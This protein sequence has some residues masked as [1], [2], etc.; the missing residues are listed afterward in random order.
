MNW[1][2]LFRAGVGVSQILFPGAVARLVSESADDNRTL[3]FI[4]VLGV[5]QLVQAGLLGGRLSRSKLRWVSG[6][7]AVHAIS[8]FAL[9]WWDGRQRALAVVDGLIASSCAFGE[10][11]ASKSACTSR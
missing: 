1:L 6:V 9:A 7:D 10:L 8:M 11:V 2:R 4:R 5:R 3:V